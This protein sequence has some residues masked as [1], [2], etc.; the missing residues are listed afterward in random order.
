MRLTKQAMAVAA[1]ALLLIGGMTGVANPEWPDGKPVTVAIQYKAGGVTLEP[2]IKY[3]PSLANIGGAF[4]TLP[5]PGHTGQRHHRRLYGRP[6][7]ARGHRGFHHRRRAPR[8]HDVHLRHPDSGQWGHVHQRFFAD[9]AQRQAVRPAPRDPAA[10]CHGAVRAGILCR[11]ALPVRRLPD[12]RLRHSGFFY[13]GRPALGTHAQCNPFLA[14]P[15]AQGRSPPTAPS[16]KGTTTWCTSC[17]W[18]YLQSAARGSNCRLI[19]LI[20]Y[21]IAKP[22]LMIGRSMT[23]CS[24]SPFF[25]TRWRAFRF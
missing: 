2:I 13:V 9:Q 19:W 20:P 16:T 22:K 5:G 6:E 11:K 17:A 3:V 8:L 18:I 4:F 1:A 24:P 21:Q 12:V 23:G 14:Q 15:G 10:H 25:R 7:P